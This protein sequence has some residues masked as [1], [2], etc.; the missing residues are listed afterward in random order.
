MHARR[1]DPKKELR[2]GKIGG[3][4]V[5]AEGYAT[6]ASLHEAT[7]RPVVLRLRRRAT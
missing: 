2:A 3:P 1:I 4:I 5:I 6:A 7:K